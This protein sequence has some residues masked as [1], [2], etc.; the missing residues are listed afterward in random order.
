MAEAIQRILKRRGL[1][2]QSP[3]RPAEIGTWFAQTAQAWNQHPTPFVWNG[4]RRKRR[5]NRPGD[6]HPVGGSAA[7]TLQ[8][9]SHFSE[10]RQNA[11]AH[12]KGPTMTPAGVQNQ[13]R[14]SPDRLK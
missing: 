5:R 2:G 9:I 8:P 3:T 11:G 4:T 12:T 7:F 1:D 10:T 6:G 13:A 14:A